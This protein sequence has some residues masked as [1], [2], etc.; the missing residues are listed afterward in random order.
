M[1]TASVMK[2]LSELSILMSLKPA[3]QPCKVQVLYQF[4]FSLH[5]CYYILFLWFF[6]FFIPLEYLKLDA[7]R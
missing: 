7:Y 5:C 3:K 1:I 4:I 2:E 6:Q